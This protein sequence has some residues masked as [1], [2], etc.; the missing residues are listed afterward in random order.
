[1]KILHLTETWKGGCG[2]YVT[3]L[4][5]RQL[6]DDQYTQVSLICCNHR[7]PEFFSFEDNP[8]LSIQRY[9]SS[10]R[11]LDLHQI[12]K[13]LTKLIESES[14]DLIHA[15]SSFA[16]LFAFFVSGDIPVIYCAHGWSF[17]Q[18]IAL[19]K[20]LMF[21]IMEKFLGRRRAA[22]YHIS[23]DEQ[24][25]AH[26]WGVRAGIDCVI[27]NSVRRPIHDKSV[28]P[29]SVDENKINLC[30]LGRFDRQK[31]ADILD[32]S[33]ANV[34]RKDLHL[35]V[36]G[37]FD[38][39]QPTGCVEPLQDGKNI[40]RLGWI[41]NA[42]I[43]RYLQLFDVIV[44]PSRWEGF[45][46]VVTEAMRNGV[47]AIISDCGG[48]MEQVIDGYNGYV[49]NRREPQSLELLL[50]SLNKSELLK[51]RSHC[52]DIYEASFTE[53]ST[54]EKVGDLYRQVLKCDQ[55]NSL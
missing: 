12:C 17:A 32:R 22:I 24:R 42:E 28:N 55:S 40:S 53:D 41:E 45:G 44:V 7:A 39:D 31:G 13:C 34:V 14:P 3:S 15:H 9:S 21:S 6:Q 52:T 16:G 48:M 18:E 1:M 35:Y 25:I 5:D 8:K 46:L 54:F 23:L 29:I 10:R 37:G 49:F 47:P 38:R 19:P 51:M 33:F 36:I 20:R 2:V 30:F 50:S 26:R 27:R 4:I 43:D 11:I